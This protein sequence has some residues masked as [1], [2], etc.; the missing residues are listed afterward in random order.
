MNR[1]SGGEVPEEL[2]EKLDPEFRGRK[3]SKLKHVQPSVDLSLSQNKNP[4]PEPEIQGMYLYLYVTVVFD[5]RNV[6]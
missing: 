3:A 1:N 6:Y 4:D 2:Q 5:V